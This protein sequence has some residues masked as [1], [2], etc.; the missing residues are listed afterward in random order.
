M[1]RPCYGFQSLCFSTLR[2]A[3]TEATTI[4][5]NAAIHNVLND[6]ASTIGPEINASS[7][8]PANG[9]RFNAAVDVPAMAMGYNSLI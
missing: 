3:Q 2:I 9:K 6:V 1:R 4:M 8:P 7:A 5:M